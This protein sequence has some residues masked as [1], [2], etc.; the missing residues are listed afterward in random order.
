MPTIKELHDLH[1]SQLETKL[2]ESEL[3]LQRE[4]GLDGELKTSGSIC[5]RFVR[6]TLTKFIVPGQFRITTGF[7]ATPELLRDSKNL[8]QCDILLVD[9]DAL[10]L[11][12]FEDSGIEVV[13]RE[14]VAGVIEVKRSLSKKTLTGDSGALAQLATIVPSLCDAPDIKTDAS[15]NRFNRHIGYDNRSSNKPILGVI[16]L[17]N[18]LQNFNEIDQLVTSADSLVDFVWTLDGHAMLP[19]FVENEKFWHYTHSAR[20]ATRTWA[21]LLPAEF[22]SAD[23]DFYRQCRGRPSWRILTPAQKDRAGVFAVVIAIVSLILSRIC[24]RPLSETE[25]DDYYLRWT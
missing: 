22:Q 14:A 7:V 12:R 23:S 20:P 11:L 19:G 2:K 3:L 8:P 24:P 9:R 25:V 6:Q 10:P 13:P 18:K 21:K 15:L 5:E 1:L 4:G 17:Q 16:A